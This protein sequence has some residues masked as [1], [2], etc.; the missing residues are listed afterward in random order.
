MASNDFTDKQG[1]YLTF[2]YAYTLL[3]KQPPAVTDI[4]DHFGVRPPSAQRMVVELEQR[5][6][7]RKTPR[8]ARSIEV[9]VPPEQIPRL[10]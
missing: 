3:H 5:G 4:A 1:E 10:W 9:L 6:L 7:I 8:A 2:I